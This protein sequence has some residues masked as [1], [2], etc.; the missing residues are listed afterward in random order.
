M[1]LSTNESQAST[2]LEQWEWTI[3]YLNNN[4]FN[5]THASAVVIVIILPDMDQRQELVVIAAAIVENF[6]KD[7]RHQTDAG[8][9]KRLR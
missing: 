5:Q 2:F 3:K 1:N 8:T 9:S 6:A 7:N 4:Y